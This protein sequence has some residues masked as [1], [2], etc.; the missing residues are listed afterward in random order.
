MYPKGGG[1][2]RRGLA[3]KAISSSFILSLNL[4]APVQYLRAPVAFFND[5]EA[6][7]VVEYKILPLKFLSYFLPSP[8]NQRFWILLCISLTY[9]EWAEVRWSENSLD[10]SAQTKLIKLL[11]LISDI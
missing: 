9:R 7:G 2:M 5:S 1:G 4:A 10:L 8:R 11:L 3:G 6:F